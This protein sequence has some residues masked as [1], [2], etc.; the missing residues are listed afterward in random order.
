MTNPVSDE[1]MSEARLA[2]IRERVEGYPSSTP[3][4]DAIED[5]R[6]LLRHADSLHSRLIA[7]EQENAQLKQREACAAELLARAEAAERLREAVDE[8]CD[9]LSTLVPSAASD[10]MATALTAVVIDLRAA[11]AAGNAGKAK[12]QV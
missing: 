7:A 3:V 2:E 6:A 11:L 4:T 12:D 1:P 8:T 5:R 10:D 9:Y